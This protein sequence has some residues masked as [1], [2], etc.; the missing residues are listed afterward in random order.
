MKRRHLIATLCALMLA[1]GTGMADGYADQVVRQLRDQG[2]GA[3]TV[4][5]TWLGRTRI[6]GQSGNG[7]REIIIDPRT[8]EILRDLFLGSSGGGSGPRIVDDRRR[9]NDDRDDDDRD[10][11][12]RDD[13]DRDD[14]DNSGSGS[15]NSGSGN[16]NDNDDDD[17]D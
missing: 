7:S 15:Q 17:N 14:N 2:Y 12:D 8:G 13:D 16:S 11:D 9:D 5:N 3:I 4:N 1:P 6:V 10:D